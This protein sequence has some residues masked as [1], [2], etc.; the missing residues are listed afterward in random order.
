MQRHRRKTE[1]FFLR[2]YETQSRLGDYEQYLDFSIF[3]YKYNGL[4]LYRKPKPKSFKH[5][6]SNIALP[7]PHRWPILPHLCYK[8]SFL[9]LTIQTASS[10][11]WNLY[12]SQNEVGLDDGC[13]SCWR[14]FGY[15]NGC[16][17]DYGFIRAPSISKPKNFYATRELAKFS[18]GDLCKYWDSWL[19][20]Q[21]S[22]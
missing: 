16:L 11:I 5:S 10:R 20:R 7:I 14:C 1:M 17:K 18:L 13:T 22:W 15:W 21:N 9:T 12:R 19:C 2:T 4:I 8:D 6:I 3:Y